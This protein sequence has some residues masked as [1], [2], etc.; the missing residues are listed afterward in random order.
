MRAR[1]AA[2]PAQPELTPLESDI[3]AVRS[4]RAGYGEGSVL[5]DLSLTMRK[6]A[7]T[8]L[9]GPNGAGK[10]TLLRTISGLLTPSSGQVILAGEDVT[11]RPAGYRARQ[12]LYHIAEGRSIYRSLTVRENIIMQSARGKEAQ[13]LERAAE[14]FPILGKR[15]SQT[16][17]TLSGGEQQ[18]LALSGAYV[19]EPQVILVDEPS[20]GLAPIVIDAVFEF[21]GRLASTGVSLLIVD[22]YPQ[23][24]LALAEFAYVLRRGEV[25]FAG[26]A[27]QLDSSDVL[28]KY[29]GEEPPGEP[30]AAPPDETPVP[31]TVAAEPE[32]GAHALQ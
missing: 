9:I 22:Q 29:L 14:A 27:S 32:G 25:V 20:L 16:A 1:R 26:Q 19:R 18:M 8:A 13:A 3:V 30:S 17:G 28:A 24:V 23:R 21:L 10:S 12:G 5:F 2:G 15:L 7:V 6:S 4:V 31:E 11:R